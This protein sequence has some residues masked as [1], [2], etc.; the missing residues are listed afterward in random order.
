MAY[1]RNI[2]AC[3]GER[4]VVV[5]LRAYFR[6]V[7]AVNT[8]FIIYRDFDFFR[9]DCVAKFGI[10]HI[11]VFQESV[12]IKGIVSNYRS[13]ISAYVK[14]NVAVVWDTTGAVESNNVFEYNG[15]VA[16]L[17]DAKVQQVGVEGMTSVPDT[18]L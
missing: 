1:C 15:G 18:T 10:G 3:D 5:Y 7:A 16:P 8:G 6:I 14:R 17:I 11:V 12:D 9:H 2:Y 4:A 13:F